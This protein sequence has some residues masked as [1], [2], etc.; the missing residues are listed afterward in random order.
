VS[1][2]VQADKDMNSAGFIFIFVIMDTNLLS[3]FW[4]ERV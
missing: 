1:I 4:I 3:K 2:I